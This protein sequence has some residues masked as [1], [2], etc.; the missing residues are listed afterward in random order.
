M[1]DMYSV[2]P[3]LGLY[4]WKK[5]REETEESRNALCIYMFNLVL[6]LPQRALRFGLLPDLSASLGLA[7]AAIQSLACVAL[8]KRFDGSTLDV[9][10]L[11]TTDVVDFTDGRRATSFFDVKKNLIPCPRFH[12][13]SV[14]ML[15]YSVLLFCFQWNVQGMMVSVLH[16]RSKLSSELLFLGMNSGAHAA[17]MLGLL[18]FTITDQIAH[19]KPRLWFSSTANVGFVVLSLVSLSFSQTVWHAILM[20]V[21][22]VTACVSAGAL[23]GACADRVF[24]E[25]NYSVIESNGD[26]RGMDEMDMRPIRRKVVAHLVAVVLA[27]SVLSAMIIGMVDEPLEARVESA[28]EYVFHFAFLLP[29]LA[30]TGL[31]VNHRFNLALAALACLFVLLPYCALDALVFHSSNQLVFVVVY[32]SI[33]VITGSLGYHLQLFRRYLIHRNIPQGHVVWGRK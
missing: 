14:S 22:G 1:L 8:L 4:S 16:A 17:V 23:I 12:R 27:F 9:L 6:V 2:L 28:G 30:W 31:L 5:L 11:S 26:E 18:F 32:F 19:Q 21:Q 24:T 20:L 7:L 33:A 3:T 29:L 25:P 10:E 13:S 15:G